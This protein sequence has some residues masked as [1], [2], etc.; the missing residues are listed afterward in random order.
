MAQST[1][2]VLAL[3]GDDT[4][5][6]DVARVAAAAGVRLV[7]IENPSNRRAWTAAAAVV[8]DGPAALRCVD[9]ALPRRDRIALVGGSVPAPADWQLA[10]AVGAQ[11]VIALPAEDAELVAVF[12][13]ATVPDAARRGSVVAVIGARGGAGASVFASA[14]ALVAGDALLVDADP[15]SGGIDLVLGCEDVPGLRWPDLAVQGGRLTYPAL[16][17]ALPRSSGVSVLSGGRVG[18]DIDVAPL[19]AVLD[20][21]CGGGVTVVCDVPRRATAAAQL[22]VEAADLVVVVTPADV[23]AC[24]AAAATRPWLT[25]RNPNA[26]VVVR[27]PAPGGLRATEVARLVDLP[28]LAAMRPAAGI[29]ETL[30]RGGV[31]LRRRSELATAARRVLALMPGPR[32]SAAA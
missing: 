22:A 10:I 32:A 24:A 20:A 9:R 15:W 7:R 23:R 12:S 19:A 13:A 26:G 14:L 3:I 25:A 17:D 21:G 29:A 31:T 30:E 6:A 5:F 18:M 4:L 27:G 2:T 1:S 11:H 16:R 8:L 28:L